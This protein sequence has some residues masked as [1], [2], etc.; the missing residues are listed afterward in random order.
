MQIPKTEIDADMDDDD[1]HLNISGS[2]PLRSPL[3][4]IKCEISQTQLQIPDIHQ[5][6]NDHTGNLCVGTGSVGGYDDMDIDN[7]IIGDSDSVVDEHTH[8]Q[9]HETGGG[10]DEHKSQQDFSV[11]TNHNNEDVNV[12]STSMNSTSQQ[13]F[14]PS[15]SP[16]TLQSTG[17][18]E[19]CEHQNNQQQHINMPSLDLSDNTASLISPDNL[20]ASPTVQQTYQTQ[21]LTH[22]SN[23]RLTPTLDICSN[24]AP[25]PV[26]NV[27]LTSEASTNTPQPLCNSNNNNNNAVNSEDDEVGAFFKAVAMKIRSAKLSPVAFTDLQIDILKVINGSLR[28][29]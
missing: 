26:P 22:G 16:Q 1:D 15:A 7:Y 21:N 19:E 5:Q 14:K 27:P 18:A 2:S 6:Q 28:N 17:V 12:Q 9:D 29:H 11:Y 8:E 3:H 4:N 10:G 23:I 25:T 20:K 24:T 13:A